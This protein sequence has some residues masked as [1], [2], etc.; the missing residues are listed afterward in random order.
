MQRRYAFTVPL[1]KLAAEVRKVRKEAAALYCC[2]L[3][4]DRETRAWMDRSTAKI[5]EY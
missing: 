5:R 4:H 3:E 2:D 1:N